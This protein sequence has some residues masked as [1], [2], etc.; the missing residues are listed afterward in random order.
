MLAVQVDHLNLTT[1]CKQTYRFQDCIV[2]WKT[3]EIC[4][5]TS[6]RLPGRGDRINLQSRKAHITISMS[7]IDT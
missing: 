1:N 3:L 5:P 7:F 2:R 4:R 6:F